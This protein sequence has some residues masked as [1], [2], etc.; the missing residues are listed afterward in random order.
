MTY[1]R[2]R[3]NSDFAFML[4]C[5]LA[6]Y[7]FFVHKCN[8]AFVKQHQKVVSKMIGGFKPAFFG[9]DRARRPPVRPHVQAVCTG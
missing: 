1:K 7:H 5:K 4:Q 2:Y 3:F 6:R 9:N 8:A